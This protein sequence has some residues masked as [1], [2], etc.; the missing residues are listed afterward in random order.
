MHHCNNK[1]IVEPTAVGVVTVQP[2]ALC[3]NHQLGYPALVGSKPQLKYPAENHIVC[4]CEGKTGIQATEDKQNE[5]FVHGLKKLY[6]HLLTITLLRHTSLWLTNND[7]LLI[8]SS[9]KAILSL[10]EANLLQ[11]CDV[12]WINTDLWFLVFIG[13]SCLVNLL[14]W[15]CIG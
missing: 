13:I 5:T 3:T 6:Y 10:G 7:C 2:T 12:I 15:K 1:S 14:A 11:S 4:L 8:V 9:W